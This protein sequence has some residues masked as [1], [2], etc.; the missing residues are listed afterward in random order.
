MTV[1]AGM[2]S[3]MVV[4]RFAAILFGISLFVLTLEMI[5]YSREILAI[6]D[7]GAGMIWRYLGLRMP[8]TLATFIPMSFLLALLLSLAELSYRSEITAIWAS[9]VSPRRFILMLAPLAFFAGVVHFFLVDRGVP[10]AAPILR[11]WG[12]GDYGEKQLK[13]GERD[14]IWMR[15]GQDVL[16]AGR[17]NARSTRL[18]DVIIFKRNSNGILL[19]QILAAEAILKD[20]VWTLNDVI[21]VDAK[22]AS[23]TKL[24]TLTYEGNVQP[25]QAGLRSGDP[26]E[27]TLGQLNYFV[28]NNGFGVR[29]TH[30]YETW[31]HRRLSPLLTCLIMTAICIPLAARFRRGGGLGVLFAAGVALGFLYFIMDGMLVSAGELGFVTPWIAAWLPSAV[32]STIALML[33]LRSARA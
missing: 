13:V 12:I 25:A 8:A 21:V 5:S 19:S 29:S 31:W 32:F 7:G 30:V 10:A 3:R 24:D 17:A 18:R 33:V 14:P 4:V 27:M 11:E 22:D 26:E 20:R 9:G 15:N 6:G 16:R 28:K 2:L 1:I 23:R